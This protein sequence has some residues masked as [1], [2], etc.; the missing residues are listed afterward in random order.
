MQIMNEPVAQKVQSF[1]TQFKHQL[2][3]KG[4]V[5]V[6]ADE[7]PSGIFYLKEGIVKEYALSRNGDEV[8]VNIFKSGAFFPMSWAINNSANKYFFGAIS[9]V[10]VYKAPKEKV[11]EFIKTEPDVLYDLLR[12]VYI[13]TDGLLT[14]LTYLMS[15]NA[16]A[17][18]IAEL[19]IHAKRF[20]KGE[21]T[22]EIHLSETDLAAQSGMTRETV[23][24]EM[25]ILKEKG[26]VKLE[27]KILLIKNLDILEKELNLL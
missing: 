23:S 22:I 7:N 1:F 9:P 11:I 5:L 14:R 2:Y 3:K 13:G 25:K 21:N 17:R 26:L 12:R 20:G 18:L 19:I 8:V 6:R 27:K 4:E 15:E 24:R 10:E 16:Y